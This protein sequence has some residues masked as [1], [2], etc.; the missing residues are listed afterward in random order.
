MNA[1]ISHASLDR[2]KMRAEWNDMRSEFH[3]LVASILPADIKRPTID[4]R[5]ST[6]EILVHMIQSSADTRHKTIRRGKIF[7]PADATC[8]GYQLFLVKLMARNST[9]QALS[10]RY[11]RAFTAATQAWERVQDDEC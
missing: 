4:T 3:E 6:G 2:A 11:D 5:W 10:A 1:Q 8:R 7:E 9:H